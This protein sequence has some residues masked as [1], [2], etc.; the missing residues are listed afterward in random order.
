MIREKEELTRRVFE[1]IVTAFQEEK[2]K[3]HVH[4]LFR[5]V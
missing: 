3:S 1:N 2:R 5:D 4:L